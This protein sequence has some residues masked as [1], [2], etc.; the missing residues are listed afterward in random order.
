ME[1]IKISFVLSDPP[2]GSRLYDENYLPGMFQ[3]DEPGYYEP[4]SFGIRL[5]TDLEVVEAKTT[6][7]L[8]GIK[9][10]FFQRK[11]NLF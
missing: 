4:G 3:S 10:L 9:R 1:Y 2:Y 8:I 7:R 5:E 11:T 6:V